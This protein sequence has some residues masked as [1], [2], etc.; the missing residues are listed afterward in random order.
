MKV[1]PQSFFADGQP[2][3]HIYHDGCSCILYKK[4]NIPKLR[5]DFFVST[6][7]L[8][9]VL[10][11]QKMITPY[12]GTPI[13]VKE[14]EF[15]FIPKD[16]YMIQDL[17]ADQ[18]TFEGWLFFFSDELIQEFI[19]S[20]HKDQLNGHNY[21][22]TEEID[23]PTFDLVPSIELYCASLL[24][25]FSIQQ[26]L[27]GPLLRLKLLELLHIIIHSSYASSFLQ[28]IHTLKLKRRSI[29]A[30]MKD[31]FDKPLK[32]EDYAY[33]T[34]RSLSSFLRDFKRQYNITPKQW[35]TQRRLEKAYQIL[36]SEERNITEVAFEVGYE[37]ISHFIKAFRTAYGISPKQFMIQQRR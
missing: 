20:L 27:K 23:L 35:L 17:L 29:S 33:L 19:H 8:T 9:I 1:V 15:V 32:V 18:G 34:G 12:E 11:G 16:V 24:H 37:N 25:F 13:V 30:F 31:H 5:T 7:V 28:L 10:K 22:G 26:G 14:N 2:F 36:S 4:V 3:P 6:H 21:M